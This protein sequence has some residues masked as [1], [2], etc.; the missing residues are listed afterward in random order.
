MTV[1][2]KIYT[3]D[4]RRELGKPQLLAKYHEGK[5][6]GKGLVFMV[7]GGLHYI[8]S[9]KAPHFSLTCNGWD[10][11]FEFGGS[12]HRLVLEHFPDF[13]DIAALHLADI[14]GQ[15]MYAAENAF[16]HLGG[17]TQFR[18]KRIGSYKGEAIWSSRGEP[19]TAN[20]EHAANLLRITVAE[21][22]ALVDTL[23][24][25]YFSKS[26]GFMTPNAEIEAKRRLAA[27]VDTQKPRWKAEAEACIKKHDLEVY[28]DPWI[29]ER[30][31]V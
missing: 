19:Y 15:P 21:A 5:P 16:Y 11:G 4:E 28:G 13:A 6:K 30:E 1:I 27:W 31:V 24:G 17:C 23:F 25:G 10:H 22:E 14:H 26:G 18:A 12:G 20:Y 8:K 3:L 9:N 29:T 7:E 2:K